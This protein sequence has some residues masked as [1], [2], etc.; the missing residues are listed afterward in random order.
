MPRKRGPGTYKGYQSPKT[1]GWP[2]PV[3]DEVRIVYGDYRTKHPGESHAIKTRGSRIAWSRAK[4]KYPK[5]YRKHI[6]EVN[7]RK[8]MREH[9]TLGRKSAD[10]LVSDHEKRNKKEIIGDPAIDY[11]RHESMM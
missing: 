4:H 10:H 3:R 8:E 1:T 7:V 6:H 5:L 9:P 2:K 11:L